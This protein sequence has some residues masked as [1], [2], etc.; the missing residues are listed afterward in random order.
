MVD[1]G[2]NTAQGEFWNSKPGQAWVRFDEAM[3]ERLSNV[4]E[5]L[6]KAVEPLSF[7]SVLDLGCGTGALSAR[8]TQDYGP[9][10]R[11]LGSDISQIMLERAQ[12]KN[13]ENHNVT[14][15]QGDAQIDDFG[16]ERFD[17]VIS[18]FGSMFFDDP[19][20]AFSNIRQAMSKGGTLVFACWAPYKENEFFY[21]PRDLLREYGDETSKPEARAAGPFAFCDKEYLNEILS[22]SGYKNIKI[23]E[24]KTTLATS[25]TPEQN[26]N[27]LMKVGFG[28]RVIRDLNLDEAQISQIKEQYMAHAIE[29]QK[30]GMISYDAL[31]YLVTAKA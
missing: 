17:L 26:A 2:E 18:R 21:L 22:A 7:N 4:T 14:F 8:L 31:I 30:D 1:F 6:M 11:L 3:N 28:A 15:R 25:D 12:E 27:L 29:R 10:L 13:K 20:K 9:S 19:I 23:D 5:H 24:V 16:A